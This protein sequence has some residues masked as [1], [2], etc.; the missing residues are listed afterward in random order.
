M[1]EKTTL[2]KHANINKYKNITIYTEIPYNHIRLD[3]C[4]INTNSE[5]WQL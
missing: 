3:I 2:E 5:I 1:E 4:H